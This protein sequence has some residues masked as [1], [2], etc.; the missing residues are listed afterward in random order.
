MSIIHDAR[1]A[2]AQRNG[3][4]E[5]PVLVEDST[6]RGSVVLINHEYDRHMRLNC[7]ASKRCAVQAFAMLLPGVSWL[8][9]LLPM[10]RRDRARLAKLDS[11][12]AGMAIIA[13]LLADLSARQDA[14][15]HAIQRAARASRGALMEAGASNSI[16]NVFLTQATDAAVR[17]KRTAKALD[18]AA[19][20]LER[21]AAAL[22]DG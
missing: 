15:A 10:T 9:R 7:V 22:R 14:H 19:E 6:D 17:S 4:R 16:Q 3:G 21:L 11:T 1:E 12:R 8:K 5:L 18:G 13:D 20:A 2:A